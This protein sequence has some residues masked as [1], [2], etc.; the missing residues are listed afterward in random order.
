MPDLAIETHDLTRDFIGARALD[1][2]TLSVPAG[3]V[4]GLLGPNG[5]G[6]TT[7]IRLLLG[8]L[9]PT[10]GTVRVLGLDPW[11][12]GQ[13]VRE[14]CGAVLAHNGLYERLSAEDNLDFYGRVW[15]LPAGARRARIRELLSHFGLWDRRHE[16]AGAWDRGLK[17]R[18]ALARAVLHRPKLVLLDEPT[19]GLDAPAAAVLR[20]SLAGLAAR[21]GFTIFLATHSLAEAEGLCTE[22]AVM[23][24][25]RLLAV[26]A[27]AALRGQKAGPHVEIIGRG[28]D[29]SLLNQVRARPE[30][31]AADL[32]NGRLILSVLD[33]AATAPIIAQLVSAGARVEALQRDQA[34]LEEVFL[35]L[36]NEDRQA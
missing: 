18:L 17:Q 36:A 12:Q 28:F 14:Q 19:A 5:S 4:L 24:Q 16:G 11:A 9:E 35:T 32:V 8:L 26:G 13:A 2:L 21:E 20:E 27:P 33:G 31:E 15:H 22:L 7:L 3:S 34:G 29:N 10:H 25:G 23:R 6:K 30:V 1:G